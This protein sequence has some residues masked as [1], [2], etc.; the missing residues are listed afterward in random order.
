M[1]ALVVA[2]LLS[3][4]SPPL[5][6][7]LHLQLAYGESW[8]HP[9]EDRWGEPTSIPDGPAHRAPEE[10]WRTREV[11]SGGALVLAGWVPSAAI[12][13][14]SAHELDR[15]GAQAG[16]A[17][18]AVSAAIAAA[19]LLP[20]WFATLGVSLASDEPGYPWRAYLGALAIHCGAPIVIGYGSLLVAALPPPVFVGVVLAA[21]LGT[22]LWLMPAI[23]SWRF[24]P[25]EADRVQDHAAPDAWE[26]RAGEAPRSTLAF[27]F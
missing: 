14:W 6:P 13:A 22:E 3:A 2:V 15:P 9:P 8:A 4:G 27:A 19:V 1:H 17:A 25:T 5:A 24:H 7:D 18:L 23:A 10:R 20:P 12:F 21:A 11:L 16:D 26:L